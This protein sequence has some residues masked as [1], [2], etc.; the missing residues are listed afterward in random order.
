MI[1]NVHTYPV[2]LIRGNKLEIKFIKRIYITAPKRKR[3]VNVSI[4]EMLDIQRKKDYLK[5]FQSDD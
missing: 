4:I 2:Y 3:M 1:D 5:Q